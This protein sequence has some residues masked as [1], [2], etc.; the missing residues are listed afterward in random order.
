MTKIMMPYITSA[1]FMHFILATVMQHCDVQ[2]AHFHASPAALWDDTLHTQSGWESCYP[3][4]SRSTQERVYSALDQMCAE[5]LATPM[6][7]L[8]EK[9]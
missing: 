3:A 2:P 6:Q 4:D 1:D 5:L 8:L 9:Y 7:N